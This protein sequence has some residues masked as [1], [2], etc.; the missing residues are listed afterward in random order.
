MLG[1]TLAEIAAQKAGILPID[2]RAFAVR[3]RSAKVLDV[4]VA[5]ARRRR[6]VLELVD[7][8]ESSRVVSVGPDG[9]VLRLPGCRDVAL[10]LHGRHQ[11]GNALLAM[12][13]VEALALRDRRQLDGDALQDGLRR[14]R[15]PGR[16]ERSV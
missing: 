13:V 10:G 15:L 14:L 12:R 9:T 8:S 16:F 1:S 5:E 3:H 7:T 2:G 6:C 4:I 11:A